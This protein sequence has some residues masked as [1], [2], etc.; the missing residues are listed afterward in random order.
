MFYAANKELESKLA[1]WL[2]TEAIFHSR[3]QSHCEIYDLCHHSLSYPPLTIGCNDVE[4]F[5]KPRRNDV[6]NSSTVQMNLF[7]SF[8]FRDEQNMRKI[9]SL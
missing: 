7:L 8:A 9:F 2:I 4:L 3:C 6:R 1:Y 5:T